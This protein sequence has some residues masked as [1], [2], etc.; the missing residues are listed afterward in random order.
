MLLDALTCAINLL[1]VAV[2]GLQASF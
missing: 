2:R 1:F